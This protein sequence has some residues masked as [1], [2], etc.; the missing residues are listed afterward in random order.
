[1]KDQKPQ[2]PNGFLYHFVYGI[3]FLFFKL[4]YRFKI[5][6]TDA[7]EIKTPFV[8]LVNHISNL[9][10]LL[11]ML[12]LYPHKL[13]LVATMQMF[14]MKPLRPFLWWL[15]FIPKEQFV[16]DPKSIR[17]IFYMARQGG[18]VEIFPSG[19]SSYTGESTQ[20]DS[21]II[22]LLQKIKLPVYSLRISGMHIALPK[23]DMSFP[24]AS[25]V[26][27][28]VAKL[29][30][31]DQLQEQPAGELYKSLVKALYFNDY[32]WQREHMIK[33]RRPRSA[34][35]L[36]QLLYMCPKCKAEFTVHAERNA[37]KCG[38][39]GNTAL[40]DEYGFLAPATEHDVAF[41][42]PPRWYNWQK[43]Q[44]R[45]VFDSAAVY[46]EACKLFHITDDGKYV[47]VGE[48]S[49][50]LSQDAL[51]YMGTCEGET[52]DYRLKNCMYPNFSN[53]IRGY[54]NI[55]IE[56]RI[57]AIQ[58]LNSPAVFKVTILKELFS[59]SCGLEA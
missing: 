38:Q 51:Q 16:S 1:M 12:A 34:V 37:L 30:S 47:L 39:C 9:D 22:K 41:Q 7:P 36:E 46:S 5:D 13:N 40:M 26:E 29:F 52:V 10:F 4:V 28:K 8:L 14:R 33:A 58:P 56:G 45:H 53:E 19:Q 18:N 35:G 17:H 32:A 3:A 31:A 6:Q 42:T 20:I 59:E 50:H 15:G 44:Y 54:F 25:R 55:E 23:W 2:K 49:F 27:L 11:P 48:G 21:N 57:Y 24:R 43:E